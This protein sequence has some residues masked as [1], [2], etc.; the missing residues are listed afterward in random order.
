MYKV[1]VARYLRRT[2]QPPVADLK[3]D[4][5]QADRV[6][7]NALDSTD[8]DGFPHIFYFRL[9]DAETGEVVAGPV[10]TREPAASLPLNGKRPERVRAVVVVEDDERALDEA[11]LEVDFPASC[12]NN[13]NIICYPQGG[14]PGITTCTPTQANFT[15]SDLL[16]AAGQCDPDTTGVLLIAGGGGGGAQAS[17]AWDGLAGGGGGGVAYSGT[18]GP[19]PEDCILSNDPRGDDGGGGPP[20]DGQP[21]RGSG[22]GSGTGGDAGGEGGGSCQAG[23]T[24][25]NGIGGAGG[26]VPGFGTA[27]WVALASDEHLAGGQATGATPGIDKIETIVVI[28]DENRSF[29]HLFPNFPGANGIAQA[30][31]TSLKQ[32]DRDGRV[33]P[34]LPPVWGGYPK[35]PAMPGFWTRIPNAPFDIT[36]HPNPNRQQDSPVGLDAIIPSPVHEFW[37][38]KMQ[39]NGGRNDMFAAWSSEGGLPL[40]HYSIP[41]PIKPYPTPVGADSTLGHYDPTNDPSINHRDQLYLWQLANE[42][43]LADHFHMAAF[44]GS[45][46]NHQWLACACTPT[47][48]ILEVDQDGLVAKLADD[49]ADGPLLTKGSFPNPS[50]ALEGAPDYVASKIT[51]RN[52]KVDGVDRKGH[53]WAVNTMQP[54]YQPSAGRADSEWPGHMLSGGSVVPPQTKKILGDLLTAKGVSWVRYAGGWD[55]ALN[56]PSGIYKP[57]TNNFQSHHQPY[58]YFKNYAWCTQV[59]REHLQD[60]D[61]GSTHPPGH[62]HECMPDDDVSDSFWARAKAGTLPS[63]VSVKPAGR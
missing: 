23:A 47:L 37:K 6:Y 4:Q 60:L 28:Y 42:Y 10:T 39:I 31:E 61:H 25:N 2:N 52:M 18:G 15:T 46:L 51:P 14:A 11:E 38:N 59:R 56:D 9:E 22:G 49:N 3:L 1:I 19:C 30:T 44:G 58:N 57:S 50:S 34:H 8:E 26:Y 17:Y 55:M 24:G 29:D 48:P 12:S 16:E 32:L 21:G 63:V 35:N 27:F 53:F 20:G 40:G 33:L 13:A 7:L 43:A 45:F 5:V 54:P 41:L 36:S 62:D